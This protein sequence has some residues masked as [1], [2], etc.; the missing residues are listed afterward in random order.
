MSPKFEQ[1]LA[2]RKNFIKIM[3]SY[4]LKEMNKIPKHFRNNIFWNIGHS[5]VTQQLLHYYLSGNEV[6]IP[7]EWVEIFK[8]G[9]QP[10]KEYDKILKKDIKN[11]LTETVHILWSDYEY[12][13]FSEYKSYTTSF[14]YTI[15]TI[16]EALSF[17]TI[18]EG[19]HLGY[20]LALK[21]EL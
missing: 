21:N 7:M 17:N 14:G 2:C 18:H 12:G 5:L 16:E 10:E 11:A 3:D 9:T 15:H 1:L 6:K 13:R 8:K 19:M 4:S 20:I